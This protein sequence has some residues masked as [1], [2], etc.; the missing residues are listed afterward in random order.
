M[1]S[2]TSFSQT[3]KPLLQQTSKDTLFCFTTNQA[4]TIA[5][6][7]AKVQFN[8]AI[9][10]ALV[11]ENANLYQ[12]FEQQKNIISSLGFQVANL[13]QVHQNQS[14]Y[15]ST[16]KQEQKKRV[17]RNRWHKLLLGSG[18]G[19]VSFIAVIDK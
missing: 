10:E 15:I 8:E 13:Q 4:K 18:L 3:I 6:E 16:L 11:R 5:K 2:Y 9:N 17:R 14:A 7:L 12:G 1:M 19:I